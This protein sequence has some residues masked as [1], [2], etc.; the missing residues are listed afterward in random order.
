MTL[1]LGQNKICC[2]CIGERKLLIG[3]KCIESC[4][5]A[6]CSLLLLISERI[7]LVAWINICFLSLIHPFSKRLKGLE[8]YHL[9]RKAH[10]GP[11]RTLIGF[12]FP[13][14]EKPLFCFLSSPQTSH[15]IYSFLQT[16]HSLINKKYFREFPVVKHNEH[17]KTACWPLPRSGGVNNV[18]SCYRQVQFSLLPLDK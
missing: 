3:H 16:G 7:L 11:E 18:A 1:K 4:F 13:E 2:I 12:R 17:R 8:K 5:I 14:N 15:H 9:A 10:F 6:S